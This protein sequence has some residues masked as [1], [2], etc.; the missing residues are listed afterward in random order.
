MQN[1]PNIISTKDLSYICDMFNWN[2]T[3]AKKALNYS[4][5]VTDNEIKDELLN[6]FDM[7]EMANI[8]SGNLSYGQQRKLEIAR[9]L[10][11]S[12]TLLLL[13][14]PAA[15]MNPN[16]T[17]ELMN[18]ISFIRKE[19]NI[20]ILLIEHDMDLVMGICERLYVLNF[21]KVIASGL[22]EEIQNNKEV[23]TAYLGE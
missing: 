9:A 10:A 7:A 1:V 23:I 16:E 4:N 8:V 3:T 14:E 6:I 20:S 15:G 17:R 21:G 5:N 2:F 13:D 11:T 19:F 18:T 12:P 22:P